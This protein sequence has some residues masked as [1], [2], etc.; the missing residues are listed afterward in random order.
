MRSLYVIG[1]PTPTLVVIKTNFLM[2]LQ[3][4]ME[5]SSCARTLH[6]RF[7]RHRA[8][9]LLRKFR[10]AEWSHWTVQRIRPVVVF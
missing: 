3:T 4:A 8:I 9:K 2:T 1:A 10:S 5:F 7:L 6:A